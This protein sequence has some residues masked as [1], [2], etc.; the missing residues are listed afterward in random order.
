MIA[1]PRGFSRKGAG[2]RG[3]SL[4]RGSRGQNTPP[5]LPAPPQPETN[6][7][8]PFWGQCDR[9]ERTPSGKHHWQQLGSPQRDPGERAESSVPVSAPPA[10]LPLGG[11]AK[12]LSCV[13]TG[14]NWTR[15]GGG[16]PPR[17]SGPRSRS[18]T[19]PPPPRW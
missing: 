7:S 5:V 6:A 1:E 9:K 18:A 12:T 10:G 15:G 16:G 8:S 14:N 19:C 3:E 13:H 11:M 2:A 17:G 4:Q